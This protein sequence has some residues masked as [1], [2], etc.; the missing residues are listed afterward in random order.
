[1]AADI[2]LR[3]ADG[4]GRLSSRL[5]QVLVF[6]PQRLVRSSWPLVRAAPIESMRHRPGARF[7]T[8]RASS[9][10]GVRRVVAHR[11]YIDDVPP[12][13]V[14]APAGLGRV[15][16]PSRP[17]A[18]PLAPVTVV[19]GHA[20]QP[21]CGAC[22]ARGIAQINVHYV[23]PH[24]LAQRL[25]GGASG[26]A[27]RLSPGAERLLVREVAASARG[28]FGGIANREGFAE[29]LGRV[30]RDLELGGFDAAGADRAVAEVARQPDANGDKLRELVRLYGAYLDRTK[31][32]ARSADDY[33]NADPARLE[34]PLLVYGV[35]SQVRE[36]EMRLF[37]RLAGPAPPS[38]SSCRCPAPRPMRRCTR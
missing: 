30:F 35:W 15:A 23:R 34:G 26:S 16:K 28:Y 33:R 19:V 36:L 9:G 10:R 29:A 32:V 8:F 14:A 6:I 27:P 11:G 4:V 5:A 38:R 18:R 1:V 3:A 12:S 37:E 25:A 13:I 31:H 21:Y 17:R 20:L 7:R 22:W 2:A 24:E